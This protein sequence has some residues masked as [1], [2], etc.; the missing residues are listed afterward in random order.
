MPHHL[1]GRPG[2]DHVWLADPNEVYVYVLEGDHGDAW[3]EH[4]STVLAQ[5]Q[6]GRKP[7]KPEKCQ[8]TNGI[9]FE[10]SSQPAVP[11]RY[12]YVALHLGGLWIKDRNGKW[13]RT[14]NTRYHVT[15]GYLP[16]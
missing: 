2:G 1:K 12:T 7:V 10:H 4:R 15:L 11:G 16:G 14:Y 8:D 6:T 9:P 5:A 13:W 3:E